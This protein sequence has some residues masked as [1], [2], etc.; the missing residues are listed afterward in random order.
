VTVAEGALMK[1]AVSR[2]PEEGLHE[3]GA[4]DPRTLDMA[5]DDCRPA[6]PIRVAADAL[7][8]DRQLIVTA[9]MGCT[10][11]CACA[12]CLESFTVPIATRAILTYAV[13]P[14]DVVDITD[15]IRQEIILEYPMVPVC[16]PACKG[17]CV[18]CGQNLNAEA[19]QHQTAEPPSR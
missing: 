8:T 16:Q 15:D 19:C 10:L 3:E 17:L 14:T 7:H 1:I 13:Q 18:T 12:R 11:E 2:I 4:I 5:R 6:S 9:Q